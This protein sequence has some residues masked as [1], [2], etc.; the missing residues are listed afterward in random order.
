MS[1]RLLDRAGRRRM[2]ANDAWI[3]GAA[4]CS[5]VLAS[6]DAAASSDWPHGVGKNC[7][8]AGIDNAEIIETVHTRRA[9]MILVSASPRL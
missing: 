1:E 7:S 2:P 3:T 4:R 8:P 5:S 9:P 6:A